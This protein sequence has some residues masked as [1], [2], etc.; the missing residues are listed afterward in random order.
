M[1]V[2]TVV[3]DVLAS[4]E[5]G[6]LR[7]LSRGTWL[8]TRY[9][10]VRRILGNSAARRAHL[11]FT[12]RRC[13]D[14][15]APM[16]DT[17]NT[18][19]AFSFA[20]S[21]DDTTYRDPRAEKVA[22]SRLLMD[23]VSDLDG[24]ELLQPLLEG[25]DGPIEPHRDLCAPFIYAVSQQA[26]GLTPEQM[27][28][29]YLRASG[30]VS[31]LYDHACL[32][33]KDTVE[34][35]AH[36]FLEDVA[37]LTDGHEKLG[38]YHPEAVASA[39]LLSLVPTTNLFTR[40]VTELARAPDLQERLRR[41]D[42]LIGPFVS[43]CER[44][45][46]WPRLSPRVLAKDLRIGDVELACGDKVLCDLLAANRDPEIWPDGRKVMLDRKPAPN[47]GFS[48]GPDSCTGAKMTRKLARIFLTEL[49]ETHH[50]D[51][52]GETE[53]LPIFPM[54]EHGAYIPVRL[55]RLA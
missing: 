53:F 3:S 8:A 50:I 42:E 5:V 37:A 31:K 15:A 27:Q 1:G 29:F 18:A 43:E 51:V 16:F 22:L 25:M 41:D 12:D 38:R 40:F 49:L 55:T 4:D 45:C 7:Q 28:A 32:R 9:R 24:A 14:G 19:C 33:Y 39:V 47:L 46:M 11:A 35:Q 21:A 26:Y 6:P 23:Q 48:V 17:P 13:L 44:L 2:V 52:A 36:R 10:D 34:D 30:I 54:F 20:Q